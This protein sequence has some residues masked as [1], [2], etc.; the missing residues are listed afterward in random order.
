MFFTVRFSGGRK[1]YLPV[2][3]P[4]HAVIMQDVVLGL[5]GLKEIEKN[6]ERNDEVACSF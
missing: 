3:F 2:V 4:G 6:Q 1:K 5:H